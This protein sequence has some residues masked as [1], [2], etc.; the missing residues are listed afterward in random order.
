[1]ARLHPVYRTGNSQSASANCSQIFDLMT[2]AWCE[3]S[4]EVA[5]SGLKGKF[6]ENETIVTSKD[7]GHVLC[8]VLGL[9]QFRKKR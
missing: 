1:M 4:A 5:Q 8:V 2:L 6:T 7:E 9:H 3:K